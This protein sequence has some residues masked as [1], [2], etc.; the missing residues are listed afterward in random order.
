MSNDVS[1]VGS[2]ANIIASQTFPVGFP[3]NQFAEDIDPFDFPS[4]QIGNAVMGANGDLQTW[5]SAIALPC[6]LSAIIGSEGDIA[7]QTIAK[8]NLAGKGKANVNDNITI[9]IIYP[10]ATTATF[11]GGKITEAMFGKSMAGTG[12]L[13]TRSYSFLFENVIGG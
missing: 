7:L 9:V 8:N 12:R 1:G 5:S 11:T 3:L 6:K 2:V 10:D 13:K 4:V